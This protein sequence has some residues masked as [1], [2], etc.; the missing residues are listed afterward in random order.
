M[1]SKS[2]TELKSFLKPESS[3]IKDSKQT[4]LWELEKRR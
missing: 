3:F 4:A 2:I 1:A